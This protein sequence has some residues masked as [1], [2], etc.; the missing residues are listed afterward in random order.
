MAKILE[1]ALDEGFVDDYSYSASY[2]DTV[3][4][5][6]KKFHYF[7]SIWFA[8]NFY[9]RNFL[10]I[11]YFYVVERVG[12]IKTAKMDAGEMSDDQHQNADDWDFDDGAALATLR[13]VQDHP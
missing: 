2:D 6:I 10:S 13:F 5:Q 9:L 12:Q 8:H 3:S 11:I 1:I 7:S 4:F